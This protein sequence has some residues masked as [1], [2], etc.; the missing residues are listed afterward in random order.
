MNRIQKLFC[1]I[2]LGLIAF[3]GV[4]IAA[5]EII[6]SGTLPTANTT[7][8]LQK[9]EKEVLAGISITELAIGETVKEENLCRTAI[10]QCLDEN[11]FKTSIDT[12]VNFQC[13]EGDLLA[14]RDL[15]IKR[16]LEEIAAATIKRQAIKQA[17]AGEGTAVITEKKAV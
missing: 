6:G 14:L 15:A 2:A 7:I 12:T 8:E 17:V 4:A 5:G 13:G 9:N 11:C 1:L 10:K 3:A 16:R